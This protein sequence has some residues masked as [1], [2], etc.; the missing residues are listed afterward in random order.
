MPDKDPHVIGARIAR[1]RHQLDWTQVE[2]AE[3]LG[4]SPSTVANWERGAAYP[5]KKL[6]KVEHVLGIELDDPEPAEP[7]ERPT[8]AQLADLRA[9][10]RE[11]LPAEVAARWL[12][13]LDAEYPGR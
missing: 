10:I 13:A 12:A 6:G 7:E 11:N 4:V 8:P 1:R 9:N 3:R 5:K 2:L